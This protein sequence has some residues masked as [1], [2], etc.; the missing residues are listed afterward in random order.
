MGGGGGSES[1]KKKKEWKLEQWEEVRVKEADRQDGMCRKHRRGT[2]QKRKRKKG[3][4]RQ[5]E[6]GMRQPLF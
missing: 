6:R 2:G 1:K 5:T 3:G 4:E